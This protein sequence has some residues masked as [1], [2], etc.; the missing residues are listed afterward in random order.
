MPIFLLESRCIRFR[1]LL[2]VGF[3]V[4][5]WRSV[6]NFDKFSLSSS[7]SLI[8]SLETDP[9]SLILC[10]PASAIL[11]ILNYE[12]NLLPGILSSL[13]KNDYWSIFVSF[14]LFLVAL[15]SYPCNDSWLI[16]ALLLFFTENITFDRCLG[17]SISFCDFWDMFSSFVLKTRDGLEIDSLL[18]GHYDPIY[19]SSIYI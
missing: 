1:S 10:F 17:T 14:K 15:F 12:P 18:S 3:V 16:L 13:S 8:Y 19:L 7:W 9:L 2:V 4:T 6:L 11:S 5:C